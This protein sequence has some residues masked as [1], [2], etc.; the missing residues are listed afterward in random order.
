M[1]QDYVIAA[2]PCQMWWHN[3]G[4]SMC[5]PTRA[6]RDNGIWAHLYLRWMWFRLTHITQVDVIAACLC[7]MGWYNR[8]P[9]IFYWHLKASAHLCYL[10][11]WHMGSLVPLGTIISA[12]LYHMGPCC[13]SLSM[14]HACQPTHATPSCC[15]LD[16]VITTHDMNFTCGQKPRFH[17]N[18]YQCHGIGEDIP[19]QLLCINA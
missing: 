9:F 19:C 16:S 2:H 17:S 3:R 4:P 18:Q 11:W 7:N 5:H 13:S 14:W 1:T 8:G 10:G 15:S 12:H 6:T